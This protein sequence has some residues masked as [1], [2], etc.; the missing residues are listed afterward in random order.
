[1]EKEFVAY[2]KKNGHFR[3]LLLS[4][5][6]NYE[7]LGHLG[8]TIRVIDATPEE[9]HAIEGLLGISFYGETEI[10]ITYQK[11]MKRLVGT[12]FEG[13]DFSKVL[14]LYFGEPIITK[15]AQRAGEQ[16]SIENAISTLM[17]IYENSYAMKWITHI[18]SSNPTLFTK[19][20]KQF[21]VDQ[22]LVVKSLDAL[23]R[24]PLWQDKITSLSVFATDVAKDPHFFDKGLPATILSD[25]IHYFLGNEKKIA[26]GIERNKN[27]LKAGLMKEDTQ[28]FC[29]TSRIFAKTQ[30]GMDHTGISYFSNCYEPLNLNV[31]N[32]LSIDQ[33]YKVKL[34]I[35]VENPSVF[36]VLNET[37]KEHTLENIAFV[38]TNGEL[39]LATHLLLDKL[40]EGNIRM[41]YA[42]DFDPEGL[43]IADKLKRKYD[44]NLHFWGYELENY[45]KAM[46]SKVLDHSRL[47]KLK[48]CLSVELEKIKEVLIDRKQPGYQEAL[49]LWYQ[50]EMLKIVTS[51]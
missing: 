46:S 14:T 20:I 4:L 6:S 32:L 16:L 33:I 50:D 39:N 9:I 34:V 24:L 40:H 35:I 29:I 37:A 45:E 1:M 36:H 5:K 48:N 38:C 43:L 26:N 44:K 19:C 51:I 8:G 18:H 30:N 3:R 31:G 47:K 11:L 7:R 49:I 27:F 42:G 2:L 21:L 13:I 22:T 28:N 23:N 41:Y 12:K 10:K 15:Q 17:S 25:A